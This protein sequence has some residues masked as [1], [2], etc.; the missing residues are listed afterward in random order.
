MGTNSAFATV[1]FDPGSGVGFAGKG[2][3]QI[4]FGWSNAQLQTYASAVSF[5]FVEIAHYDVTCEVEKT[6]GKET[7]IIRAV[8]QDNRTIADTVSSE[9][10]KNN[11]QI[12]GFYLKGFVKAP[13]LSTGDEP[14]VNGPCESNGETGVIIAVTLDSFERKVHAIHGGIEHL[15]WYNGASVLP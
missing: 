10:R 8:K 11:S 3:V 15:I 7:K 13:T 6:T 14:A 4:P 9:G 5:N 2:D 12:T 1:S